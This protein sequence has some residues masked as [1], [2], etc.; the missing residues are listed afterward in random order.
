MQ[1]K[2]FDEE[3]ANS[4]ERGVK[5]RRRRAL[6]NQWKTVTTPQSGPS[7]R[8]IYVEETQPRSPVRLKIVFSL[9]GCNDVSCSYEV[10]LP[11]K[12]TKLLLNMNNLQNFCITWLLKQS[13]VCIV[14][15]VKT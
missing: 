7:Y 9:Q 14:H 13:L 10:W 12:N 8:H 15:S 11:V 3:V 6:V 1:P 2:D 5:R 4:A